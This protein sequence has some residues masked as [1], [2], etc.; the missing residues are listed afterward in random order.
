MNVY[1]QLLDDAIQKTFTKEKLFADLIDSKLSDLG[2]ILN[3]A[4]IEDLIKKILNESIMDSFSFSIDEKEL[5][6]C[7]QNLLELSNIS[8][9]LTFDS[10]KDLVVLKIK[11]IKLY[12]ILFKNLCQNSQR[13]FC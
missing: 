1:Q 5:L 4:Q 7:P 11:S 13:T 12:K 10:E 8:I 9:P 3:N 2:I 6:K